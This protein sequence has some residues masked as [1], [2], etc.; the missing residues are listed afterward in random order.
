[1]FLVN[2]IK[3]MVDILHDFM[4]VC[5]CLLYFNFGLYCSVTAAKQMCL[6]HFKAIIQYEV[7]SNRPTS[8][9]QLTLSGVIHASVLGCVTVQECLCNNSCFQA[10]ETLL[11]E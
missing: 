9:T 10:C 1:M 5:A 2:V 6:I 4:Y 11:R 7:G 8:P 3:S